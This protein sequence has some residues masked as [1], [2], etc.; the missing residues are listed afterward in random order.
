MP[1]RLQVASIASVIVILA[2][3]GGAL[4]AS[5]P[6]AVPASTTQAATKL[7]VRLAETAPGAGLSEATV[8]GS[9]EKIYLHRE[10]IISNAD[11]VLA[12]VVPGDRPATFNVG[13]MFSTDGSAKIEKAT[14]A[15]LNKPLAILVDGRVVA[16]PTLRA[17]IRG[18]AVIT[19]E[20]TSAEADAIASALNAR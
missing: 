1:C 4:S 13:V 18:S 10:T 20:F 11:V 6:A 19:G 15:H 9:V 5:S 12:R 7:D 8:S 17:E 14:Q 16:A 3:C 2:L